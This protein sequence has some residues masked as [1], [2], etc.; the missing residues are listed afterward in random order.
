MMQKGG[1]RPKL[2]SEENISEIVAWLE[3]DCDF[4]LTQLVEKCRVAFNQVPSIT[5]SNN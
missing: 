1:K 4:T 3:T 2:L 5:T